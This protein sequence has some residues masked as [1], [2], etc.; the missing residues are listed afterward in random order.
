MIAFKK[1][2][3]HNFTVRK[4]RIKRVAYTV[5]AT[6]QRTSKSK[7][8]RIKS[9]WV[10]LGSPSSNSSSS[11]R[12]SSSHGVGTG[13]DSGITSKSRGIIPL[14]S[15]IKCAKHSVTFTFLLFLFKWI[16]STI[17]TCIVRSYS[18]YGPSVVYTLW[19]LLFASECSRKSHDLEHLKYTQ[20]IRWLN[21]RHP[22]PS[23]P[24]PLRPFGSQATTTTSSSSSTI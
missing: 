15:R 12:S 8:H 20:G 24:T 16:E 7:V 1:C 14:L 5:S 3:L 18:V 17:E 19:G 6:E 2:I 13:R 9:I 4:C 22:S 23:T 10:S 21:F 11:N